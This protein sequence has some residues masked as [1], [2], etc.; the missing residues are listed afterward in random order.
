MNTDDDFQEVIAYAFKSDLSLE[1][2]NEL[3]NDQS[4]WQWIDRES[5][6]F[7]EYLSANPHDV[8]DGAD[9][10]SRLRI[11]KEEDHYVIDVMYDSEKP[12][13]QEAWEA[14]VAQVKDKVLPQLAARDVEETEDFG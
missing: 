8:D 6:Y 5:D 2:M 7:G 12:K 9:G 1:Q 13:A 3:L 11:F 4:A 10:N 14:L